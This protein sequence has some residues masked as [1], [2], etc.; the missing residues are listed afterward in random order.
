MFTVLLL[1]AR[2][3]NPS[4]RRLAVAFCNTVVAA[5]AAAAAAA[6]LTLWSRCH[7]M[8]VSGVLTCLFVLLFY[9]SSKHDA[10]KVLFSGGKPLQE[11]TQGLGDHGAEELRC[12][13]HEQPF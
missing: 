5:T 11:E 2:V 10:P 12:Y 9:C 1:C 8:F 7:V 4:Y 6:A 13:D 3:V